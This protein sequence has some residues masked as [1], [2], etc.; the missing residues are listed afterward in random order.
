MPEIARLWDYYTDLMQRANKLNLQ[1]RVTAIPPK[2]AGKLVSTIKPQCL[3]CS[4]GLAELGRAHLQNCPV[5]GRMPQAAVDPSL[6]R[7]MHSQRQGLPAHLSKETSAPA[8]CLYAFYSCTDNF[9]STLHI[10]PA[11]Y[12]C[13]CE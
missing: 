6:P 1:R 5:L 13:T 8:A 3:H 4:A 11:S 12:M 2:E 10:L 7:P 9:I